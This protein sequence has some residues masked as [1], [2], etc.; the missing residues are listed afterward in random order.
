MAKNSLKAWILCHKCE[1]VILFLILCVSLITR[2]YKIDGFLTFL[3]D[4]G[5]DVRVVRNLLRGDLVFI[6]PQT[7]VGNMYLGPLYYYLIAPSLFISK[8]NP[9][10]PA[11]MMALIGTL[12]VALTWFVGR[13]WFNPLAGLIAALLLA[14]SP[15]AIIYSRS[16]WNPNPMPYFALI[17]VYGIYKV[18][19]YDNFKWLIITAVS[20]AFVLQMHYMSL[21]LL[22]LIGIFWLAS[23]Y[24]VRS[25]REDLR[26]YIKASLI[27]LITFI[28]LMSPMALFDLKH[29]F[30]NAKAFS[31]L[32][33][34]S[35]S[36]VINSPFGSDRLITIFL[37]ITSD[38]VLAR[39]QILVPLVSLIIFILSIWA[40]VNSKSKYKPALTI[41]F[42]WLILS[43]L[44]L[45]MY[46][47]QLYAHY[48]GFVMPAFYLLLGL[49]LSLIFKRGSLGK[50]MATMT[51]ASLLF[52]NIK[53]SPLK[54][55][56]N[57]Q[58]KRTENIVDLIIK[59]SA[60]TKFNFGLIAKQNYDESYRYF[61][62]N[63]KAALVRGEDGVTQQL[64]VICEDGDICQ[65]EGNSNWQIAKFGPSHVV[66][67][68]QIDGIKVYKLVHS[69]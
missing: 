32:L 45:G 69:Q 11:I 6:G 3:G 68:W 58:M 8:L 13:R 34:G 42:S 64:F 27:G 52:L 55:T 16:S 23:L 36:T 48:F 50:I 33:F 35:Q 56:P 2:L 43:I 66:S 63:K 53:Y 18:W 24:K 51:I 60:G 17:S 30:M 22:P 12:T 25:Q 7:S 21:L 46:R 44:G 59:E 28:F 38:L 10:G 47:Q 65:P 67:Q 5:R 15:V 9:I 49:I 19:R 54:E 14:L 26:L 61:L 62:E 1:L 31:A 41:L 37:Q 57:Y 4:E 20:T 40:L 39:Q 29:G